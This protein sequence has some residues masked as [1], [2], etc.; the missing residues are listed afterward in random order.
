MMSEGTRIR[1]D[2]T[3]IVFQPGGDFHLLI[4]DMPNDAAIPDHMAVVVTLAAM[5]QEDEFRNLI[6]EKWVEVSER[7]REGGPIREEGR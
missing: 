5:L 4:P 3:A 1:D 6:G 2:E 7:L